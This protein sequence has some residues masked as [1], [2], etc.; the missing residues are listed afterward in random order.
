MKPSGL[1][2]QAKHVASEVRDKAGMARVMELRKKYGAIDV[3]AKDAEAQQ[4][5]ILDELKAYIAS[6]PPPREE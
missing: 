1:F 2:Q 5:K 4:K 6:P 3:Y